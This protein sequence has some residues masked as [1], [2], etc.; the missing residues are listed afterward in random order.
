MLNDILV[1]SLSL[2][3]NLISKYKKQMFIFIFNN[4]CSFYNMNSRF[5]SSSWKNNFTEELSVEGLIAF[6]NAYGF[7]V[8]F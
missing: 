1:F 3:K 7:F 8:S 4:A 2:T 5:C 6:W